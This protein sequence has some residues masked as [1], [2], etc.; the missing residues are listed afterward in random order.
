MSET[1][2][3][4]TMEMLMQAKKKMMEPPKRETFLCKECGNAAVFSGWEAT[5]RIDGAHYFICNPCAAAAC[6]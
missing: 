1:S 2:G 4:L 6:P 5:K 3:K